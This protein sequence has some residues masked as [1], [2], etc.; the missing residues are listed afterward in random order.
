V[1]VRVLKGELAGGR[2]QKQEQVQGF[3]ISFSSA[4]AEHWL[5]TLSCARQDPPPSF[6][7]LLTPKLGVPA[8][9]PRA[10][11]TA[12]FTPADDHGLA[13]A[14]GPGGEPAK[15]VNANLAVWVLV[16]VADGVAAATSHPATAQPLV[17]RG[18]GGGSE[19]AAML[20]PSLPLSRGPLR[21]W[22]APLRRKSSAPGRLQPTP[23]APCPLRR[24]R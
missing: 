9:P 22:A 6:V 17:P 11:A 19:Y 21:R 20:L 2:T 14:L 24:Q 10:A 16:G 13:V 3:Y 8:R 15:N 5:S 1:R 23:R 4:L 7:S 18:S 12:L